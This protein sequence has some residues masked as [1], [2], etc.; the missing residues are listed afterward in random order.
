[1]GGGW[2]VVGL[3]YITVYH[4]QTGSF[5]AYKRRGKGRISH[6]EEAP[7]SK[8]TTGMTRGNRQLKGQR[9]EGKQKECP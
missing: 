6:E 7:L 5:G 2:W 9:K 3:R 1:M 4:D 8:A